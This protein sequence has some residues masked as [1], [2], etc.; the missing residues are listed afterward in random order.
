MQN[1]IISLGN[2][3]GGR[4]I[5]SD[6]FNTTLLS[7]HFYLPLNTDTM[8]EDAL[9]PYLIT[10]CS[11]D[12]PTI[13]E[14]NTKLLRLYGAELGCSV[15]KSGDYLH[16]KISLSVINSFFA[17]DNEDMPL[18]AAELLCSLIFN[19][20]LSGEAFMAAD[21]EREK[22]KT[23][24]RIESEI[25]NKR[26]YA[27]GRL[28]ELMFEG[29]PYGKF[30]YGTVDEV[31]AITPETAYRAYRRLLE[32]SYIQVNVVGKELPKVFFDTLRSCFSLILRDNVALPELSAPLGAADSVTRV[33]EKM[34]ITQGKLVMGFSSCISG[35]FEKALP[36]MLCSDIFGGGPYS[37]LFSNVREKLSLC[38]YCS[39][40]GRRAK[41]YLIVDS[42]V[43]AEKAEDTE[44]AILSELAALQRGELPSETVIASKKA[45]ID[46]LRGYYDNPAAI[47]SWY[48]KDI[49]EK[50]E[51]S[52]NDVIEKIE[53]ITAEEI[54]D[55]AKG[56]KLHTVFKLMPEKGGEP[57][58]DN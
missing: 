12:Y 51:L 27:R 46:S 28:G 24:E 6:R 9:L 52:P 50:G 21:L 53:K 31:N 20:S 32:K 13:T 29:S 26:A 25:N 15:S 57:N 19:P 7:L 33:T 35:D 54:I 1:E 18:E 40:A 42:G 8:A 47:D 48:S 45:I 39:S 36:L 14:L 38:Y 55:T 23:V 17:Y 30:I 3:V 49:T 44:R 2:G 56:L 4:F 10:S 37:R 58:A 41:G 11:A 43:E 34:D 5:F 22:R 16:T